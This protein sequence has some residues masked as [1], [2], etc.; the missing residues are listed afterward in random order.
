MKKIVLIYRNRVE[1]ANSIEELFDTLA[2][3]LQKKF[4]VVKYQMRSVSYLPW[5]IF[6]LRKLNPDIY[7]ITGDV[8]YMACFLPKHNTMLTIHDI[9][10]YSHTMRGFKK[11]IYKWLYLT[12][13]LRSIC[14]LSTISTATK[15]VLE[16]QFCLRAPAHVISNCYNK[17]LFVAKSKEFN[18]VEPVILHIGTKANKNLPNLIAALNG[19]KCNL[20]IIGRLNAEQVQLL[21]DNKINYINL[22]NLTLLEI[23]NNYVKAD[24][25]AFASLSEGFGL[26]IIEAQAVGRPVITSNFAPMSSVAGEAACLIDPY[27]ITE[28]RNGVLKII[29]DESYRNQLIVAGFNN[30]QRYSPRSTAEQYTQLYLS[31]LEQ[32]N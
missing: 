21:V 17:T 7:H 5:D 8:H 9:H 28:I 32:S 18:S 11:L 20:V 31:M 24:L 1:G 27:S 22:L 30:I 13:P 6:N 14:C 25:V 15:Q 10:Y 4:T 29:A 3:E 23:Y 12:L 16:Q 26:P 19:I 2:E